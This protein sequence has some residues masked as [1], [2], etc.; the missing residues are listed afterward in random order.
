MKPVADDEPLQ[1]Q[2]PKSRPDASAAGSYRQAARWRHRRRNQRRRPQPAD[3]RDRSR[4][5]ILAAFAVAPSACLPRP[6]ARQESQLGKSPTIFGE[7]EG[8]VFR[9]PDG[10]TLEAIHQ[11]SN[12]DAAGRPAENPFLKSNYFWHSDKAYLP[13]PALLTMLHAVELPPSGGDTQFADMIRAHASLTDDVKRR[14][15]GLRAVHSLEYMRISTDDRPPTDEEKNAA[16][17]VVHPLVRTHPETG[18]KSLFPRHVLLP[19]RRHGQRRKPR[20]ARPVACARDAAAG[21]STRI[22]GVRA[23]WSS[24]TIAACCIARWPTTT[25]RRAGACCCAWSSRI[26]LRPDQFRHLDSRLATLRSQ[27][28]SVRI[29]HCPVTC[30]ADPESSGAALE[31][32][33]RTR[34]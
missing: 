19:H 7:V 26:V 5:D 8:N 32:T 29:A 17:P 30:A 3:I 10:S 34:R 20:A 12:L 9:N 25:W 15:A 24:G 21:L 13:V 16:P 4:A 22:G 23:T 18:E 2:L 27:P 1:S 11:I 28:T 14:I 6:A 31:M 33:W